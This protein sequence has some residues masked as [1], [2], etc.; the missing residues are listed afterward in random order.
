MV[1]ASQGQIRAPSPM[2]DCFRPSLAILVFV[3]LFER[4]FWVLLSRRNRDKVFRMFSDLWTRQLRGFPCQRRQFSGRSDV[5]HLSVPKLAGTCP[6][7]QKSYLR[8]GIFVGAA[9]LCHCRRAKWLFRLAIDCR[10]AGKRTA[11]DGDAETVVCRAK[12]QRT[13]SGDD[14]PTIITDQTAGRPQHSHI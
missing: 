2:P 9:D 10:T 4:P 12:A 13:R 7:I 14:L 1:D 6:H 3:W 11:T 5:V 8:K